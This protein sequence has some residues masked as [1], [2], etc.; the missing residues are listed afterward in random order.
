MNPMDLQS[1]NQ[2]FGCS[3]LKF[4]QPNQIIWVI[5]TCLFSDRFSNFQRIF[6]N[7]VLFYSRVIFGR[8]S[9]T[10]IP[11]I[12]E[13]PLDIFR[14]PQDLD[15]DLRRSRSSQKQ[16]LSAARNYFS[17]HPPQECPAPATHVKCVSLV[18]HCFLITHPR[19]DS[20]QRAWNFLEE[21]RGSE[22][23]GNF[24]SKSNAFVVSLHCF[25]GCKK[26]EFVQCIC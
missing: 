11:K 26:R 18:S 23:N 6:E 14:R 5:A 1:E 19:L 17:V 25:S 7:R 21:N 22:N 16:N 24:E 2:A 15:L 8:I 4:S 12:S 3:N 20:L 10:G 13:Y 9:S